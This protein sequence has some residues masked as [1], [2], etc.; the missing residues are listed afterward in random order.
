MKNTVSILAGRGYSALRRSGWIHGI[1]L[2]LA[3]IAGFM[4]IA[5]LPSPTQKMLG[6]GITFVLVLC[7]GFALIVRGFQDLGKHRH[8][9]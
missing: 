5:Y 9:K 7:F 1:L 2:A 3:A 4:S 6:F 8:R